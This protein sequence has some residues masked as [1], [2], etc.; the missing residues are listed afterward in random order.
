V[1]QAKLSGPLT[2]CQPE[3][4][5]PSWSQAPQCRPVQQPRADQ[6]AATEPVR[7][8]LQRLV[9]EV[10]GTALFDP[11]DS[12][13]PPAAGPCSSHL[14]H[15]LLFSDSNHLTNAG[16]WLLYPRFKAFLASP[17]PAS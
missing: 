1:P 16:A 9:A 2:L 5:R 17:S 14:G 8:F 7:S 6:I 13:C 3:W 12:V 15:N 4:F 10:P 11:F